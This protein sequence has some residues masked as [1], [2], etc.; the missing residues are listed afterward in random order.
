[1]H[2]IPANSVRSLTNSEKERYARLRGI[3]A[4]H[5]PWVR[6]QLSRLKPVYAE[7]LGT[8][9]SDEHGRVYL[10]FEGWANTWS[11]EECAWV[12]IHELF[13]FLRGH[14]VR[15]REATVQ[16][17]PPIWAVATDMEINDDIIRLK[18][19]PAPTG[20]VFPSSCSFEDGHLAEY[21]A[22][23]LLDQAKENGGMAAGPGDDQAGAAPGD[24]EGSGGD[25]SEGTPSFT[26][27]PTNG[28]RGMCGNGV[29]EEAE[30]AADE[31]TDR[32]SP[33]ERSALERRMAE[34]ALRHESKNPGSV[35]RGMVSWAK[36]RLRPPQ[37]HWTRQFAQVLGG[38]TSK[39]RGHHRPSW[40]EPN[41][42]TLGTLRMPGH[43]ANTPFV[44]IAL[45]GSGS[46]MDGS[47]ERATDEAT[48]ILRT[49]GVKPH[50]VQV[51]EIEYVVTSVRRMKT[52][53]IN[54]LDSSGGGTDMRKAYT[55]VGEMTRNRPNL[56]VLLTDGETAWPTE[57]DKIPGVTC[58]AGIITESKTRYDDL[59]SS[60]PSWIKPLYIPRDDVTKDAA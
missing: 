23:L 15:V 18:G 34:D 39:I 37:I 60:I 22:K 27:A 28:T 12:L 19:L 7:N 5:V 40:Y 51:M 35:P 6:Y 44:L 4:V 36:D 26:Q 17:P 32:I 14:V 54:S 9:A 29:G 3:A 24:D 53:T 59:V 58:I 31:L 25:A 30:K 20:V 16:Y 21:Y 2:L 48:G 43:R 52:Q 8:W 13:H 33:E 46:M 45:D 10:S 41:R 11:D 49:K 1:M 42:R 56:M 55:A 50:H 47:L 57:A 38:A